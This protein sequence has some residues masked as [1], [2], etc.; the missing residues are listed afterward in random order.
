MTPTAPPSDYSQATPTSSILLSGAGKKY[1]REWIF[2]HL[3]YHFEKGKSYAITGPN[4]S[5]KSTLLQCIAGSTL[6]SEGNIS[7][8]NESGMKLPESLFYQSI[9]MAA[10]YLELI[11]E[12]TALEFLHF[13]RQFKPLIPGTTPEELLQLAQLDTAAHK[14]IRYFSSGMK[15]RLKLLQAFYSDVPVILLD[16]PCTNLDRSGFSFYQDLC[17]GPGKNRMTIIGSNDP[18]ETDHCSGHIHLPDYR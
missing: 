14:Q 18:A 13:H 2:R 4:G 11:E 15:Q 1:N 16:E 5:G 12:M 7:Y 8:T 6:L 10:P 3:D 17:F 9:S